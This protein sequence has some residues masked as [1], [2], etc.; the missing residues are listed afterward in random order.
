[1]DHVNFWILIGG[2]IA[3]VVSIVL[4]ISAWI[5]NPPN[6]NGP[7]G[8]I[9]GPDV[10][11]NAKVILPVAS[12]I[13]KIRA[14]LPATG[15]KLAIE[16]P[17]TKGTWANI[18]QMD[19]NA[20]LLWYYSK[21]KESSIS[22]LFGALKS[23]CETSGYNVSTDPSQTTMAT[24]YPYYKNGVPVT[25]NTQV[26][27]R[28][29]VVPNVRVTAMLGVACTVY[30]KELGNSEALHLAQS[31]W[32]CVYNTLQQSVNDSVTGLKSYHKVFS[33]VPP[34]SDTKVDLSLYSYTD[35]MMWFAIFTSQLNSVAAFSEANAY[36]SQF[37]TYLSAVLHDPTQ[38]GLCSS[39]AA[40]TS[41]LKGNA[42][43]K[44]EAYIGYKYWLT[45][46]A[47]CQSVNTQRFGMGNCNSA[48]EVGNWYGLCGQQPPTYT[49]ALMYMYEPE[50]KDHQGALYH[51][52]TFNSVVDSTLPPSHKMDN[53]VVSETNPG[54]CGSVF[55]QPAV[56]CNIKDTSAP[57]VGKTRYGVKYTTEGDGVDL[58]TTC[59]V[60]YA[61]FRLLD[62][63]PQDTDRKDNVVLNTFDQF[64]QT[65]RLELTNSTEGTPLPGSYRSVLYMPTHAST[66]GYGLD[67]D[68]S[69]CLSTQIWLAICFEYIVSKKDEKWNVWKAIL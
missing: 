40:N 54:G 41:D 39:T 32:Y 24:L 21:R 59:Q 9:S 3:V 5:L 12:D 19:S 62:T 18:A 64:L 8:S 60:V 23:I 61:L 69:P 53:N 35:H 45:G 25:D 2:A 34:L 42:P 63:V 68:S 50:S 16:Y 29:Q 51:Q 65:L 27:T 10:F 67:R 44:D 36:M 14:A 20:M 58:P 6:T 38:V 13:T 17:T 28:I 57:P 31:L 56:P 47:Q 43:Y 48:A 55:A 15:N 46:F 37:E 30:H 66:T 4:L 26:D 22:G 7:R 49:T 1:M 11:A 52:M 33:G